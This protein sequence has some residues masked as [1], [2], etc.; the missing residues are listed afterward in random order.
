[1][2]TKGVKQN[3]EHIKKKADAHRGNHWK[4]SEESK[5]NIGLGHVGIKFSDERKKK[6]SLALKGKKRKP[7]SEEHKRKISEGG[8][9]KS[10]PKSAEHRRKISE[11][12]IGRVWSLESRAKMSANNPR[13]WLGKKRSLETNKKISE[14]NKGKATW[15]K[16]KKHT[17][18]AIRKMSEYRVENPNKLFQDTSIELKIEAELKR[19]GI[20]Y[21]KQVPLCKVARVDFF[22]PEQK[23]VI[24]AD[25]D[26]WHNLPKHKERDKNQDAVLRQN[27]FDVYRFWEHEI[28]RSVEDCIKRINNIKLETYATK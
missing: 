21:E 5:R 3:P 20:R 11:A 9:G 6:I 12:Q 22:I 4:L 13:Y 19:L 15:I 27:G 8:K 10:K 26:Y 28:N 1:M 24:Q 25:G 7:L 16:G 2:A 23:I 17:D 14:A 18:E